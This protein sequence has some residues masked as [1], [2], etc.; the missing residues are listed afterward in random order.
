MS[1]SE[2]ATALFGEMPSQRS[3]SVIRDGRFI[4]EDC[5]SCRGSG[6]HRYSAFSAGYAADR[7]SEA[8]SKCYGCGKR[9]VKARGRKT[10]V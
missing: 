2:A 8:C 5:P 1:K 4:L 6:R 3:P 9:L 10:N 7:V